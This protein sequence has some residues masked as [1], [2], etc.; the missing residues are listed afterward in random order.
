MEQAIYMKNR[1]RRRTYLQNIILLPT[2]PVLFNKV[3]SSLADSVSRHLRVAVVQSWHDAA[4]CDSQP[5][6]SSD[7]QTLVQNRKWIV[8]LAHLRRAAG[9]VAGGETL[10]DEWDP[11]FALRFFLR[12]EEAA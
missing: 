10:L 8:G 3:S 5:I 9:M 1:F 4:V 6:Y 7:S 11:V 12:V 2:S